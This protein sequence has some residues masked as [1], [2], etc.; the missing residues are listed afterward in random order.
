VEGAIGGA[1]G[2]VPCLIQDVKFILNF[3]VDQAA[4]V[5]GGISL[6]PF[7]MTIGT[8]DCLEGRNYPPSSAC[9]PE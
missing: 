7:N 8:V 3:N 6:G 2:I 5:S 4:V 1:T 9:S